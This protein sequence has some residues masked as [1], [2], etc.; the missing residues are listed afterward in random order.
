MFFNPFSILD[1]Y[2]YINFFKSF[3]QNSLLASVMPLS[4]MRR[5]SAG[6]ISM[7]NILLVIQIH[8]FHSLGQISI[9]KS[10]SDGIPTMYD[11]FSAVALIL[12]WQSWLRFKVFSRSPATEFGCCSC[13]VSCL[14]YDQSF[15]SARDA[16]IDCAFLKMYCQQHFTL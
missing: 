4:A 13:W 11:Y 12:L 9:Y 3:L 14:D 10:D 7:E 5:A 16:F 8:Q 2:T 15:L 6:V 1:I